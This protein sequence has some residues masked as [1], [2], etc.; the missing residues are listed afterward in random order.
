MSAFPSI[1]SSGCV[2]KI[3]DFRIDMNGHQYFPPFV[4]RK[5]NLWFS[6]SF[7]DSKIRQTGEWTLPVSA[8]PKYSRTS[9]ARTLLEP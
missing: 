5:K 4:R 7:S 3:G 6:I 8:D 1:Q 2:V 9:M